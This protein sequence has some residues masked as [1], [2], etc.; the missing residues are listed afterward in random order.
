MIKR[1]ILLWIAILLAPSVGA[2]EYPTRP[3]RIIVPWASGGGADIMARLVAAKLSESMSQQFIV[4][5]KPGATGTLGTDLVAKATPDGHTLVIGTNSTY[6]IAVALGGKLPYDPDKDLTPVVRIG[7][8]PHI[9][10]VHPTVDAR[11]V[12]DFVKLAKERPKSLAY[13]SS[14][15][16]STPQLAG[17]TFK[18][19]AGLEILHVPYKGSGQSLADTVSG[20]VQV[21]FDTLPSQ[22][23]YIRGAK[24]RPLAVLGS[25]RV[26]ALPELPTIAEAGYAGAE[27][28]TWFGLYGPGGLPSPIVEKLH[29]EVAKLVRLP[30][31]KSRFE[32]LGAD[33]GT[34]ESP[35]EFAASA[36]S[37]IARY[38]KV[39]RAAG[40]KGE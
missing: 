10:S 2:Q 40:I 38:S 33:E 20:V 5:N 11:S 34:T 26:S 29:L 28:L 14:G 19:M 25:K 37:E 1:L 21:S 9:L 18:L 39:A 8:V 17:E 36:K 7:S 22:L 35:S 31:V 16:G 15:N 3:V 12:Q 6:V 13:G 4:D 30:D 32:T 27:G 24:L 23:G